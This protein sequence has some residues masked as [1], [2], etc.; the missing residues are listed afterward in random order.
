MKYRV[1]TSNNSKVCL[2]SAAMS[3]LPLVWMCLLLSLLTVEIQSRDLRAHR[4]SELSDCKRPGCLTMKS[5]IIN[6]LP[7]CLKVGI[8]CLC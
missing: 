4:H 7:P 6:S 5:Q 2:L 8:S 3:G 1:L